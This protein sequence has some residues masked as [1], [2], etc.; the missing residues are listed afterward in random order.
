MP[1]SIYQLPLQEGFVQAEFNPLNDDLLLLYETGELICYSNS[2]LEKWRFGFP[3]ITPFAFRINAEGILVAVL[4]EGELCIYDMWKKTLQQRP[5]DLKIRLLE[6]YKNCVVLG[7]YQETLEILKPNGNPLKTLVFKDYIHQFKVIAQQDA[8]L[9]YN[10][11]QHFFCADLHAKISW[12]LKS[13]HVISDIL[14]SDTGRI[15][16]VTEYPDH[17]IHFNGTGDFFSELVNS[18]PHK[19][20]ALSKNGEYLLVLDVE[21]SLKLYNTK[22]QLVWERPFD[23]EIR[24]ISMSWSGSLFFTIDPDRILTCY[25]TIPAQKTSVDFLELQED[26]RVTEKSCTWSIKPG[27]HLPK[28]ELRHLTTNNPGTAIALLGMDGNV[29]FYS[30]KKDLYLK[31]ALPA[32]VDKI[33]ISDQLDFGYVYGESRMVLADLIKKKSSYLIFNHITA[34]APIVNYDL[35]WIVFCTPNRYLHI[36]D[37]A[38]N[39]LQKRELSAVYQK[40]ISCEKYGLILF[41][42][43]LCTYVDATGKFRFKITLPAPVRTMVFDGHR[44]LCP[45]GPDTLIVVD[46]IKQHAKKQKFPNKNAE[47]KIVSIH[48]LMLVHGD[49]ELYIL[50]ENLSI[51]ATY[52][53]QSPNAIFFIYDDQWFEIQIKARRCFGY[54][55]K[56]EMVWRYISDQAIYGAALTQNGLVIMGEDQ[57]QYLALKQETVVQEHYSDFLEL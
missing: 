31:V 14:I 42:D 46:F 11:R 8:L 15:G 54:N 13:F 4:G 44:L 36:Y 30:D 43:H 38:G 20:M 55:E 16:Y 10:Q 37:F 27:M 35:Q 3:D 49:H 50:D 22:V 9:I 24:K 19:L 17:W 28:N 33:G 2:G 21:N 56:K 40:A 25:E 7:G 18:V 47:L 45:A 12:I 1:Q 29:Y 34:K 39:L 52:V 5:V 26:I 32:I 23:N 6:F 51:R 57:L 48:P 41:N 53:V